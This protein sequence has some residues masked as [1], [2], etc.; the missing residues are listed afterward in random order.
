MK[1]LHLRRSGF[2]DDNAPV[3]PRDE[4]RHTLTPRGAKAKVSRHWTNLDIEGSPA[5]P[6]ELRD[7]KQ[8]EGALALRPARQSL[9]PSLDHCSNRLRVERPACF[10]RALISR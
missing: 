3:W 8:V 5:S 10:S 6:F 4:Q 7:R 1:K 9:L 2:S